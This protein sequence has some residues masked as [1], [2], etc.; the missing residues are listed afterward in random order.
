[1]Q[2]WQ[3][4]RL[5]E[6]FSKYGENP[7]MEYAR[8]DG[9]V[10]IAT[11]RVTVTL[12]GRVSIAT[13]TVSIATIRVSIATIRVSIATITVSIPTSRVTVTTLLQITC[14]PSYHCMAE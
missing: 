8:F 4:S 6:D 10:S 11:I 3:L 1:M 7:F 5:L 2:A 14:K 13:I 9:R 12:Y